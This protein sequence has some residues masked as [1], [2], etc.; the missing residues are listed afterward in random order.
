MEVWLVNSPCFLYS[1]ANQVAEFMAKR[2]AKLL[3][4]FVENT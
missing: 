3:V 1:L 2:G 4:C